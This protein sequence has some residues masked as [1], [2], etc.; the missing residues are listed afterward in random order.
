MAEEHEWCGFKCIIC[1]KRTNFVRYQVS[2]YGPI[3]G[4]CIGC[5]EFYKPMISCLECG[6]M[7]S[8]NNIEKS[9]LFTNETQP[10]QTNPS[11][12]KLHK[13][14]YGMDILYY[15]RRLMG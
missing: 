11:Q 3:Y 7:I 2:R 1:R 5:R 15:N 13:Q 8:A 14:F 12:L 4:N 10:R 9:K 6:I